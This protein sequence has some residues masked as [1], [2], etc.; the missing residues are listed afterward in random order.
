MIIRQPL[1]KQTF[2]FDSQRVWN[3]GMSEMIFLYFSE[4]A[5]ALLEELAELKAMCFGIKST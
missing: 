1:K 2:S 4:E 3:K 5:F